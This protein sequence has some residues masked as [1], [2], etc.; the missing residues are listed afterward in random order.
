[1]D[2]NI[3]NSGTLENLN[4]DVFCERYEPGFR[5]VLGN[6]EANDN[7]ILIWQ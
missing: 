3:S 1:M 4:F 7:G 5:F 6:L 2:K